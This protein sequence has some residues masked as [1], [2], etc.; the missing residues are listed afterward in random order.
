MA[1]DHKTIIQLEFVTSA[2]RE[3]VLKMQYWLTVCLLLNMDIVNKKFNSH[4]IRIFP[5]YIMLQRAPGIQ[6][7][8]DL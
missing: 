6:F 8:L 1:N 7:P 2:I 3:T 4:V 5:Y